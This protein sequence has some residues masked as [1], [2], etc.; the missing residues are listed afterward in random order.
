[1]GD[2]A[3]PG[4]DGALPLARE[5]VEAVLARIE[6]ALADLDAAGTRGAIA[7]AMD[8]D[9]T[10]WE[11]DVGYDL[12]EAF[13][14][15]NG[16]RPEA[17]EALRREAGE[18][19]IAISGG[20][21]HAAAVALYDAHRADRYPE[22]RAFAMMAWAFAGWHEDELAAFVDR[23]LDARRIEE[24]V[25]APLSTLLERARARGVQLFVVSASPRAIVERGVARIGLSGARVLAMTP[26]IERGRVAPALA[27]PPT[28]GDG[29]V[30]ALERAFPEM[31]GA[32]ALLAA[33]GDS[34]YDAPMLRAARVP[35]AVAPSPKLLALAGTIPGLVVLD[36]GRD[37]PQAPRSP[38]S[39]AWP[40]S[41]SGA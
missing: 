26:A 6:S 15:A 38:V 7:V 21:A 39:P 34:A 17:D 33:F 13:L 35:V 19:G 3:H 10:L 28:Y 16:A 1:M 29:K 40:R 18:H 8:A 31:H 41:R 22:D 5:M 9:G 12:F 32:G 24:R 4:A 20:G 37:R 30:R 11:G 27:L 36:V 14:S 2:P 25:H 23:V